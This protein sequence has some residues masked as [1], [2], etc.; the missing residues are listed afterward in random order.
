[1]ARWALAFAVCRSSTSLPATKDDSRSAEL[2]AAE[3][4]AAPVSKD[5]A[6]VASVSESSSVVPP[7]IAYSDAA[8]ATAEKVT[9]ADLTY[10]AIDGQGQPR[11]VPR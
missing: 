1:M 6:A 10:V 8:G 4:S 9:E 11:P 2:E 3:G 5:A 7:P